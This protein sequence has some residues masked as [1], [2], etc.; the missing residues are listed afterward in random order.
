MSGKTKVQAEIPREITSDVSALTEQPKGKDS[1]D[2][3]FRKKA[4]V[5]F[6]GESSETEVDFWGK[7]LKARVNTLVMLTVCNANTKKSQKNVS[8][9]RFSQITHKYTF[10]NC[11]QI[12][13]SKLQDKFFVLKVFW[14]FW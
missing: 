5:E 9:W 10:F 1:S 4:L 14:F 11:L 13:L 6:K 3:I 8:L 12:L 2:R 7:N